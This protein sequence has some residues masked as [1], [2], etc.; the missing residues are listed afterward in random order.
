VAW[1]EVAAHRRARAHLLDQA[2]LE[3]VEALGNI[4]SGVFCPSAL[5][6]ARR[7]PDSARRLEQQVWMPPGHVAQAEIAHHPELRLHPPLSAGARAL[8]TR[9]ERDGERL[10]GR[11]S[12]IMG[13]VTG[14]N[15]QALSWSGAAS[16]EPIVCGTDVSPFRLRPPSRRL[17]VPLGRVQQA[18]ARGAY[19]RPKVVYRFIADR[20]IAAIDHAGYL[21]L[22]SA[23]AL[24]CDDPA[25]V[26]EFVTAALNS[27]PLAFAH[28]ARSSLPR[29]LRRDLERL[30]LP[31]AGPGDRRAVVALS[32]A[33]AAG[34]PAAAPAL[35]ELIMGLFRLSRAERA[36]VRR[37]VNQGASE[38]SWPPS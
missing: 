11:V 18:A 28:R 38:E 9:L 4:F 17:T 15:R 16:G 19:A 10:A 3:R 36:Q 27:S 23:N 7:E 5:L 12:F 30:P 8:L 35:D 25:L 37:A 32:R 6:M 33:A 2:A 20:P 14:A 24:A 1:L 26:P 29:L 21:T 22:N 34:D 31:R 13:V